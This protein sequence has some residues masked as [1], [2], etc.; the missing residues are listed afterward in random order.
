[1]Y[2]LFALNMHDNLV[3]FWSRTEF[4]SFSVLILLFDIL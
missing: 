1:M 2:V 4:C 3:E